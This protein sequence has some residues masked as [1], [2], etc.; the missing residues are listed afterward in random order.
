[1]RNQRELQ[2]LSIT[3][4]ASACLH[5]ALKQERS[6]SRGLLSSI[7]KQVVGRNKTTTSMTDYIEKRDY[8]EKVHGQV[9]ALS[10]YKA[11]EKNE[12]IEQMI[13]NQRENRRQRHLN[14]IKEF[15]NWHEKLIENIKFSTEET[16][17]NWESFAKASEEELNSM[18]SGFTE[19]LL[20][21]KELEY[22]LAGYDNI[23]YHVAKRH[24]EAEKMKNDLQRL[25]AEKFHSTENFLAIMRK[26]LIE[27]AFQLSPEIDTFISLKKTAVI[28]DDKVCKKVIEQYANKALENESKLKDFMMSRL[29]DKEKFWRLVHHDAAMKAF[30]QE[31]RSKNYVNPEERVSL[32]VELKGK[33][34]EIFNERVELLN[35]IVDIPMASF[36]QEKVEMFIEKLNA[37]NDKAQGIYDTEIQ[38]IVD[39]QKMLDQEVE[40]N[41][42]VLQNKLEYYKADISVPL[43]ELIH[44]EGRLVVDKLKEDSKK[45]LTKAIKYLEETDIRAHEVCTSLSTF[46]KSIAK[47]F[48]FMIAYN[49][50][51][52]KKY[53]LSIASRGDTM[54][55]NVDDLEEAFNKE[56]YKLKRSITLEQLEQRLQ[57][58]FKIL[59]KIASEY[60][61]YT[62][63]SL[64]IMNSHQN[65]IKNTYETFQVKVGEKFGLLPMS[66]KAA[67]MQAIKDKKLKEIE[68]AKAFEDPKKKVG[69]KEEEPKIDYPILE[70]WKY[71]PSSWVILA[72]LDHIIT[73]LL[74]T[75]EDKAKEEERKRVEEEHK[76]QE[77]ERK[78]AEEAIKK[79]EAKKG[80]KP[81]VKK[82]EEVKQEV[83]VVEE[84][85]E[86]D[87]PIDPEG[88]LCLE[89]EIFID[90]KLS[91]SLT[92][93]LREHNIDFIFAQ[94][95]NQ[96]QAAKVTDKKNIEKTIEELDEHLRYLWPRKGKLEVN[97]FS[98]RLIEVKRHY[99]R[100][101]RHSEETL[102]KQSQ[103]SEEYANIVQSL[104]D[105]LI[106]YR[107]KQEE[108]RKL[109]PNCVNLAECQGFMRKSKDL[110]LQLFQYSQDALGRAR[111]IYDSQCARIMYQNYEFIESLQL[112]EKG[113]NYDADEVEY[114]RQ[115]T[116]IIDKEVSEVREK[117]Q[118]EFE[119]LMKKVEIDRSEPIK[120]FEKEFALV[121]EN[122]AAKEG[123]GKKYGAPRRTAQ[124]RLRAEMTKCEK[125][126][127]GI[128]RTI[129]DLERL[130]QEYREIYASKSEPRFASRNPSL[131]LEIRR[132]LISIRICSHKYGIHISGF[133]DETVLALKPL[134]WKEDLSNAGPAA[135]ELPLESSRMEILLDPLEDIGVQ[136]NPLNFWQRVL[137]IEKYAREESLKL[138]QGKSSAVPEFMEKYLKSM[139][140]NAE[141][142]RLKRIKALR[143]SSVKVI[144][145]L[146]M[147]SEAV[148][149]SLWFGSE[150][151][152]EQECEKCDSKVM[153]EF[154]K[155]EEHRNKHKAM[156]RPNLSNPSC[157]QELDELNK[158]EEDRSN[159][160]KTLIKS[161][162]DTFYKTVKASGDLFKTKLLNNT[163]ILLYLYDNFFTYDSYISLPGDQQLEIKRSNIK[164]LV[165]KKKITTPVPPPNV[166]PD[167]KGAVV[168]PNAQQKVPKG[169]KSWPGLPLNN[170][171][172]PIDSNVPDSQPIVSMKTHGHKSVIKCRNESFR[173]FSLLFCNKVNEFSHKMNTLLTEEDSWNEKW[174]SSVGFLKVKNAY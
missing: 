64:K 34:K 29:K 108:L 84:P 115:K 85:K 66:R 133:K 152:F 103:N 168:D 10:N 96:V 4:K 140:S 164:K 163:E 35:S 100:W 98:S 17:K 11:P 109:L 120:M 124:E 102:K 14:C 91:M 37:L 126:Q 79:E 136:K 70:E 122:I 159:K 33:Q 55:E 54:D 2:G 161:S 49:R 15:E 6:S 1:M 39:F 151:L 82:V 145:V 9:R 20:L 174:K 160:L 155:L 27:I 125:A 45:L 99:S 104:K 65:L 58:S 75:E 110:E 67:F 139:K 94:M 142:F 18:I 22:V 13:D 52:E 16:K 76:K 150:F 81:E 116:T 19:E 32:F 123:M 105:Y 72:K 30:S 3:H 114:Y 56:V 121:V 153:I 28:A 53:E 78:I 88:N 93:R 48:D 42:E 47:E 156:L 135:D 134:T 40:E 129:M 165:L 173:C 171:K 43:E 97:E 87:E 24:T 62:D 74:V 118:N 36:T 141:D 130:V 89:T 71:G 57:E 143:E 86:P 26:N 80:R 73:E 107:T 112:F 128:D 149:N 21:T 44:R 162:L 69:R 8:S 5:N 158:I 146:E 7:G 119:G 90:F 59:D 111:G 38:R 41:L 77:E 95:E 106:S 170:M 172:L 68:D 51:E 117:W 61:G 147:V 60:R 131:A 12:H 132:V 169:M 83:Q 23:N 92:C 137:D 167:K 50:E 144:E 25:E 113:G 31:I 101:D 46:W 148:V 154:E 63:D 127:A 157:R 166:V 138:F